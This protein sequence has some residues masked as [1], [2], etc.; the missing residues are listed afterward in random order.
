MYA[1]GIEIYCARPQPMPAI[2][3]SL[4]R[5]TSRLRAGASCYLA[6]S[7]TSGATSRPII[8]RGLATIQMQL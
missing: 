7:S 6:T 3:G 4:L 2:P 5:A 8:V 1:K